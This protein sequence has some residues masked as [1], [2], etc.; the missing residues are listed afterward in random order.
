MAPGPTRSYKIESLPKNRPVRQAL[1][2]REETV[3]AGQV[4]LDENERRTGSQ[5]FANVCAFWQAQPQLSTLAFATVQATLS[6]FAPLI[7]GPPR[8]KR[9]L[10]N[11]GGDSQG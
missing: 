6:R 1:G 7:M 9:R 4:P 8:A 2:G 11:L 3:H 10:H 5:T